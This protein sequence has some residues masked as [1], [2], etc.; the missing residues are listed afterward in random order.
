MFKV[1]RTLL[2]MPTRKPCQP[3]KR[4]SKN[5]CDRAAVG[6]R[7]WNGRW[8]RSRVVRDVVEFKRVKDASGDHSIEAGIRV[9]IDIKSS[10][11]A[12]ITVAKRRDNLTTCHTA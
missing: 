5:A 12:S 7:R 2:T 1:Q 10:I 4:E 8:K 11:C 9:D 3:N 6:N